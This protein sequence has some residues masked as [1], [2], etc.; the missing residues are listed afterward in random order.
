MADIME[1]VRKGGKATESE[2][3]KKGPE[4]GTPTETPK[5][6]ADEASL[7]GEAEVEEEKDH[8]LRLLFKGTSLAD[9]LAVTGAKIVEGDAQVS[10]RV[11]GLG[12]REVGEVLR[13][14]FSK[15]HEAKAGIRVFLAAIRAQGAGIDVKAVLDKLVE[16]AKR[17]EAK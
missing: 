1:A 9:V 5:V 6:D 7:F 14:F 13:A 3:P 10:F 16:Q 8:K 15:A 17:T 12:N 11:E 2:D 4:Q